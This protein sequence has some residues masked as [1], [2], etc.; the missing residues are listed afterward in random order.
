VVHIVICHSGSRKGV[1][2]GTGIYPALRG[3]ISSLLLPLSREEFETV[4]GL[5]TVYGQRLRRN[6]DK[7][8]PYLVCY[9]P[10]DQIR[11]DSAYAALHAMANTY[12]EERQ[13]Y[14][15]VFVEENLRDQKNVVK[16]ITCRDC[17]ADFSEWEKLAIKYE[18]ALKKIVKSL[19]NLGYQKLALDSGEAALRRIAEITGYSSSLIQKLL[20]FI[21]A[22]HRGRLCYSLPRKKDRVLPVEPVYLPIYTKKGWVY[23]RWD[24]VSEAIEWWEELKRAV[25]PGEENCPDPFLTDIVWTVRNGSSSHHNWIWE[26]SESLP[27]SP[28]EVVEGGEIYADSSL[29]EKWERVQKRRW[30]R[31]HRKRAQ[32]M[33]VPKGLL[34]VT[35]IHWIPGGEELDEECCEA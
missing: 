15:E 4:D 29:L 7:G 12:G 11:A 34:P 26:E 17:A 14:Y 2:G 8:E 6:L 35:G 22:T 28:P 25:L 13:K 9:H 32:V 3:Y 5:L 24:G 31:S 21:Q 18:G 23:R 1:T 20:P 27:A 33:P 30:A 19:N 16:Y 10:V